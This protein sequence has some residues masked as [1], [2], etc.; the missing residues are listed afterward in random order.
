MLPDRVAEGLGYVFG[1]E[2]A[3]NIGKRIALCG[4]RAE[5][6]NSFDGLEI[7]GIAPAARQ[8]RV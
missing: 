5:K 3:G 7:A 6:D 2:R 4:G 1:A 8:A